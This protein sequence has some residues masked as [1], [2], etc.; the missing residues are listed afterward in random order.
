MADI[1]KD[2]RA[3]IIGF[4]DAGVWTALAKGDGTFLP[5][6]L[7]L[8]EIFSCVG[9]LDFNLEWGAVDLGGFPVN[10]RWRWQRDNPGV[11]SASLCHFFS[12]T[13]T[14]NNVSIKVPDFADC[15][16]Q[17]DMSHVDTP[18]GW[19]GF[20][21]GFESSD[22]FHGHLN[23]FGTT[24][25]GG[26]GWGDH[27]IDDD[28]YMSLATDGDPALLNDRHALHTEFDSDETIDNFD[29]PWWNG[30]HNAV[31]GSE[32]AAAELRFCQNNTTFPCPPNIVQALQTAIDLPRTMFKKADGSQVEAIMTG[33]FGVDCEHDGCKSELHPVWT[34]AAHVKDDPE[35]DVWAIFVRNTGDEGYCSRKIWKGDF[36]RYTF[37]LDWRPGMNVVQVLWGINQTVFEGTAGT[38]GPEITFTPG[39]GVDVTFTLPPPSESPLIDGELHLQWHG[40][41]IEVAKKGPASS[42]GDFEL[43][44]E[45]EGIRKAMDR[46]PP[47]EW[48]KVKD[49]RP[50][51]KKKV[52]LHRLPSGAAA[53]Q[54][55]A[56]APHPPAVTLVGKPGDA[57][58]GKTAR[59]TAKL[60][61]LCSA[62]KGSPP[63]LPSDLCAKVGH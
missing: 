52:A 28:Y 40:Q 48:K 34:V 55:P 6:H 37:H 20:I 54:V 23:W 2:G 17:T 46:L 16:D 10:P 32:T 3:D 15:T 4:G 9:K 59:D 60:I 11:P 31:D 43:H 62:W 5:E 50:A 30:F 18:D 36:T 47:K 1:S 45:G 8:L 38:S 7:V 13:V 57:A 35:D 41:I 24:F 61:A 44:D 58:A 42:A 49:A 27:N 22:G 21:C 63:G 39:Q 12:K 51:G 56:L 29:T 26:L 19:N 53:K 14:V 33:M 25:K